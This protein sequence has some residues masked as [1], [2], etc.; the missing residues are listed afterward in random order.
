MNIS[1]RLQNMRI[2]TKTLIYLILAII[3]SVIPVSIFAILRG[4]AMPAYTINSTDVFI[5]FLFTF[6]PFVIGFLGGEMYIDD[7][8]E[9]DPLYQPC[10]MRKK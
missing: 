7:M 9:S 4:H 2:K 10:A 5:I 8:D 6:V 1:R 3:Y